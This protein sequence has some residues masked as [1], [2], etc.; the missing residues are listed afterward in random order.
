MK[1]IP[2][3][4]IASLPRFHLMAL[5]DTH[6]HTHTHTHTCTHMLAFFS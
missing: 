4:T 2:T 1:I 6:T 5:Q 3:W